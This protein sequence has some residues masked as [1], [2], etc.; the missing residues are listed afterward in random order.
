MLCCCGVRKIRNWF[1][2]YDN[3]DYI[4]KEHHSDIIP[5]SCGKLM[6]GVTV[7]PWT[8]IFMLSNM[9][10][11]ETYFQAA[12]RVQSPWEITLIINKFEAVKKAKRE[13]KEL[14]KKEKKRSDRG[15]K[16]I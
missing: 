5:L 13:G 7:K 15:G 10:S 9:S 14:N 11:H 8:G 4:K 2:C 12:F 1:S 6:T 16:R 3:T